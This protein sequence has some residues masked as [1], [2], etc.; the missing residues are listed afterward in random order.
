M[1]TTHT[2]GPWHFED[3]DHLG[4]N[5]NIYNQNNQDIARVY[6]TDE[7]RGLADA[8]LIAASPDLLAIL[9][10]LM[11]LDS[12]SAHACGAGIKHWREATQKA[13]LL[14]ARVEGGAQ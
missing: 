10:E 1:T 4:L 6:G 11:A 14:V 7:G 3:R 5:P 2:P 9:K 8:H 12:N 13:R